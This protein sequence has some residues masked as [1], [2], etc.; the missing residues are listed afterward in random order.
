MHRI[1]FLY[2][3]SVGNTSADKIQACGTPFYISP[4]QKNK[5]K[6]DYKTDIYSLGMIL[7]EL[8]YAKKMKSQD[9]MYKVCLIHLCMVN[10]D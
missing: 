6:V 5:K 9:N 1:L 7:F 8:Y 3:Y 2:L 4:E 10:I